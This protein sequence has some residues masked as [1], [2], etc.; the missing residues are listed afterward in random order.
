MRGQRF[1]VLSGQ[2]RVVFDASPENAP[3]EP[4]HLRRKGSRPDQ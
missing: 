3:A 1:V 2:E 4:E